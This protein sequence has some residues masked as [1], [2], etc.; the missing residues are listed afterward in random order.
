MSI[1]PRRRGACVQVAVSHRVIGWRHKCRP[2]LIAAGD[3]QSRRDVGPVLA[4]EEVG[5][6]A[7]KIDHKLVP[8]WSPRI[9]EHEGRARGRGLRR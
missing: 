6:L 4:P 5:R 2:A 8:A 1:E 7:Q 3:Q 9:I